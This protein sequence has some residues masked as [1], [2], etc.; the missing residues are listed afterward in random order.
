MGIE[1]YY[2]DGQIL[3]YNHDCIEVIDEMEKESVNLVLTDPPYGI[4]Y[5]SNHY[6]Y[7]NPHKSIYNDDVFFLPV[8]ELWDKV[9]DNG[10]MFVFYSY[11]VPMVDGRIRNVIVWVKNNHTAGDLKGDFGNKYECI[12]FMPKDK[13]KLKGY[14]YSNVWEFNRIPPGIHPT[15]KPVELLKRVI[16]C[17]TD[18]EDVVFDPF[19]GSG[20]TIIACKL[21]GRRCI[22]VEIDKGY[23][24]SIV[25]KLSQGV[26]GI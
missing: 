7:E 24:D 11:K 1:P 17:S 12:A 6:K 8:N 4:E 15:E 21:L 19:A 26:L 20:S 5:K 10:S 13:F 22:G 16:E 14:R 25:R 2:D 23:C 3:L 18:K 9:S